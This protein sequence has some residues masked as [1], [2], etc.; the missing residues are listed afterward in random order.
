MKP[1]VGGIFH[2]NANFRKNFLGNFPPFYISSPTIRIGFSLFSVR[3]FLSIGCN[4]YHQISDWSYFSRD[5]YASPLPPFLVQ[6]Y[7]KTRR[8][9]LDTHN[10]KKLSQYL[11]PVVT[12]DS[13]SSYILR[14]QMPYL[15]YILVFFSL[16]T[17]PCFLFLACFSL[18][19]CPCLPFS[20]VFASM[21]LLRCQAV[22]PLL[23][24]VPVSP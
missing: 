13:Y 12:Y 6:L 1:F 23:N 9:K 22:E 8:A 7:E 4:Q 10:K 17:L 14:E 11:T 18:F 24:C 3:I 16:Q 2:K 15:Y 20:D 19:A 21:S 5:C